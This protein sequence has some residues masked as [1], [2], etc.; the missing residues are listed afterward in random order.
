MPDHLLSQFT[1]STQSSLSQ[2][3]IPSPAKPSQNTTFPSFMGV[4]PIL[5]L[6]GFCSQ[7]HTARHIFLSV[8]DTN[9]NVNWI[10]KFD[11]KVKNVLGY[12]LVECWECLNSN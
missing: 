10:L 2:V 8:R 11:Q 12:N 1:M 4:I 7:Q 3:L 5:I 6:Y 9:S